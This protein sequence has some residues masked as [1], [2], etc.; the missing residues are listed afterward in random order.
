MEPKYEHFAYELGAFVQ[1][2]TQSDLNNRKMQILERIVQECPG[3]V[4]LHY[5]VRHTL[6]G[7]IQVLESE[8]EPYAQN[9]SEKFE[10][11]W[12]TRR[13]SKTANPADA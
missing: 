3:G 12:L 7:L 6:S 11:E 2:K 10:D 1:L 5:K 4:Q 9:D 8:I 13:M